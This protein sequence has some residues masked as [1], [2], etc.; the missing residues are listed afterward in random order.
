MLTFFAGIPVVTFAQKQ[1]NFWY[2]GK[3]A[4][5][6]FNGFDPMPLANSSMDAPEG[7]ACV[8]DSTGKLAF[9]T[10]GVNIWNSNHVKINAQ[11]LSGSATSTQSATIVPDP[12]K[13][14]EYYLFTQILPYY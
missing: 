3:N 13:P 9:Y 4:A 5:L 1:A 2:F 14:D 6:D 11:P 10:D 7:V 8:S 12:K